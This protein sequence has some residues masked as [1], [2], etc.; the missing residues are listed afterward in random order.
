MLFATLRQLR[1]VVLILTR[2]ETAAS[3]TYVV[4]NGI[5][6]SRALFANSGY[7]CNILHHNSISEEELDLVFA[8]REL[9]NSICCS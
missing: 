1:Y 6:A 8:A 9:C 5:N 2:A 4:G 3:Q 7:S